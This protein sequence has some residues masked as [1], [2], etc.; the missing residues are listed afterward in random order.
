[1]S[2]VARK[3]GL[4]PQLVRIEER[5]EEIEELIERGEPTSP[6]EFMDQMFGSHIE[7][8]PQNEHGLPSHVWLKSQF[9]TK[10][11]AIRHLVE[12]GFAI[13]HISKHLGIKYQHARNVATQKLKRGPNESWLPKDKRP[14]D[15][16]PLTT[17]KEIVND[18][19]QL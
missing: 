9:K 15:F 4:P 13:K 2:G 3:K 17:T 11:A 12:K 6:E 8:E 16:Q 7:E 14:K 18:D 1:M 5:A 19:E 10:S